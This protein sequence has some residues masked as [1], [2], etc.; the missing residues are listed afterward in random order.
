MEERDYYG[1]LGVPEG[2]SFEEIRSAF[3][4][5]ALRYLSLIHI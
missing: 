1:I 2:A 3:R 4:R 5:L